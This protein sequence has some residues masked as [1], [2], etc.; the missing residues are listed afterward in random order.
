MNHDFYDFMITMILIIEIIV[1]HHRNQVNRGLPAGRQVQTMAG[2]AGK[3][4]Q[5]IQSKPYV[6]NEFKNILQ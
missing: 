5:R 3:Q 2:K 1:V 4:Q 6:T